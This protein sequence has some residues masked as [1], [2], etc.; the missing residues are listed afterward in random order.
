[1]KRLDIELG[2]RSYPIFIG[3]G[4]LDDCAGRIAELC[5]G[6]KVIAVTD[7]NVAL[8]HGDKLLRALKSR[9]VESYTVAVAP[10]EKSKSVKNLEWLYHSFVSLNLRR[11]DAVIAFGGGVV[12]DLAGLAAATYMRGVTL[13]Q[14]P[15][16]LLAQVDSSVGGKVAVNI[17]EGKNLVGSFYQPALVISDIS[18]LDT[19]PEREFRAGMAE[20]VK[21]AAIGESELTELLASSE[22]SAGKIEEIVYVCC[23]CK[24]GYTRRD[25][26]DTGERMALN[27]GHTFGHAIEKLHGYG[28]YLHGEAV[29]MGMALAARAGEALG[30]T[31]PEAGRELLELMDACGLK[32]AFKGDAAS[33]VPLM[34]G[35][36]KNTD[37]DI[38]LILLK[39]FGETTKLKVSAG[40]LCQALRRRRRRK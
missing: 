26:R 13:I 21:Y 16:T 39:N 3:A 23:R 32:Y 28:V 35:D 22:A 1:M 40:V 30:V 9:G 25:E 11:G 8:T 37:G 7:L 4:A 12:G 38:T 29:A 2:E 20:V 18:L 10:G 6:G 19:L 5:N 36:K 27:F 24:G 33:L 31:A 34:D 17:A 14:I 15:T